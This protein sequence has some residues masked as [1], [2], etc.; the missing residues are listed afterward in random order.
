MLSAGQPYQSPDAKMKIGT[1]ARNQEI[2]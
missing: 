1:I 2:K